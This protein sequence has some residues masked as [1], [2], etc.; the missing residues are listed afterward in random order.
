[1]TGRPAENL[2]GE[3]LD[4]LLVNA[5]VMTMDPAR[6]VIEAGAVAIRGDRI[7]RV[8]T[9]SDLG[10][11]VATR[12]LDC[13]G[14]VVIPGLIDVHGH[15]GHSLLKTL[16]ADT[17]ALWMQI[18]TPT[19]FNF[20]TERF[21]HVDGLLSALERVRAGVT[22][23][24]SVI[25]S[26]PRS[27]D[28]QLGIA[29]AT[30]YADV[31]VREI[32]CVG[33]PGGPEPKVFSRW[34][35]GN[36]VTASVSYDETLAGA[37]TIIETCN[38][39]ADGLISVFITPFT[40]VPSLNPSAPTSPDQATTLTDF[41]R[42]NAR[43]IREVAS[44]HG[45]RIHSDAFG[46]MVRLAAQDS[47]AA[48]L[49]PDVHLQ[50][51]IGLSLDEV[52]I[53]ADT[54]THVGQAPIPYRSPIVALLEAGV[55]VAVTSDGSARRAFDMFQAM[56]TLQ[57]VHQ[58]FEQDSYILPVGKLL[59]MA[60]IDAARAI[61][62]DKD[63]G[64]IEAGKLADIAIVNL[65]Q[66]HLVPNWMVAHRLVYE[67][68]AHDVET[69]ICNGRIVMEDRTICSVELDAVLD[70][71]DEEARDVVSRASL[72][73][74]LSEPGWGQA[75]RRFHHPIRLPAVAE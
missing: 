28:P 49:G 60:T 31:G 8:G 11:L 12:Y 20:T 4:L 43:K 33:P 65:R 74:H 54:G 27:D 24:A 30:A 19:Y 1:M 64:S 48:L 34:A 57:L 67:A 13:E 53:L 46:G 61:G 68:V 6:T 50:H 62:R 26:V 42:Y 16:G 47:E 9:T 18:V 73:G 41:D 15:G 35:N 22:C 56:R 40:I 71:A 2:T 3:H 55:N 39:M 58:I 44:R 75:R 7:I 66:P 52:Q 72:A 63:L 45:V 23:G 32:L 5:T 25:G 51:C 59:E 36:P 38:G 37:E 21:W 10:Q 17:P 29:H 14:R 69:V 70:A